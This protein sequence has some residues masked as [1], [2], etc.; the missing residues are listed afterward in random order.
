[1]VGMRE[2]IRL[3]FNELNDSLKEHDGDNKQKPQLALSKQ[4]VSLVLE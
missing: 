4:G 2:F 1:M 3:T